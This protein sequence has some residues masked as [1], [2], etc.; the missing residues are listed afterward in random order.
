MVTYAI[1]SVEGAQPDTTETEDIDRLR[2][3]VDSL[4]FDD[5]KTMHKVWFDMCNVTDDPLGRSKLKSDTQFIYD[6]AMSRLKGT[7]QQSNA[8]NILEILSDQD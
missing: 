8:P 7:D 3:M 1:A 5:I 6:L 2:R 4:S